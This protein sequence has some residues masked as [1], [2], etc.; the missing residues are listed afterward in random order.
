ME[1][2]EDL[3]CFF[4]V[5]TQWVPGDRNSISLWN[6]N[7]GQRV[8]KHLLPNLY[9]FAEDNNITLRQA[10]LTM[11]GTTQFRPNLSEDAHQEL[12]TLRNQ[13]SQLDLQA[14]T[15]DDLRWRWNDNGQISK[16][17]DGHWQA[18]AYYADKT[19]KQQDTYSRIA[20]TQLNY[21]KS[22]C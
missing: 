3:R 15:S 6:Q 4:T 10:V 13:L 17:E 8:L 12:N 22:Y 11:A 5:S 2:K 16:E 19:M 20:L 14:G 7:W 9:S 18:F 1:I 21:I